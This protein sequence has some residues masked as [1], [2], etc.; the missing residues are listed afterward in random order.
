[1]TQEENKKRAQDDH[2]KYIKEH[3]CDK[4]GDKDF[5]FISY[6]SDDWETVLQDVVYRLVSE[7]GLNVYFDGSFDSHNSLWIHQFPENM[8]NERCK[9]VLAFLDDKYATS[10]AT[11]LELMYSQTYLANE[12][13]V[14]PVNLSKLTAITSE[15]DTGLGTELYSDGTKN[16]NA[17]SE[18]NLFDETFEELKTREIWKKSGFMYKKKKLSQKICSI[19]VAELVA[20]LG[21]NEN[22]YE[23]GQALDGIVES[24]KNACGKSVFS[25]AESGPVSKPKPEP[26]SKSKPES[27]FVPEVAIVPRSMSVPSNGLTK[28]TTLKEFSEL[29][30]Y[31]EFCE[32][33]QKVRCNEKKQPFDYLMAAL[34]RGC[35]EKSFKTTKGVEVVLNH[36]R[37]NYCTYAVSANLN[38]DNPVCGASQYTWTSNAR[39]AAGM[40]GSGALGENSSVFNALGEE[41]TLGQIEKH[42]TEKTEPAFD[43]NDNESVL[44]SLNAILQ[45]DV[46]KVL[47]SIGV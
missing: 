31:P 43:I 12:L 15:E 46:K 14:V 36:A 3:I 5:V 26:A 41:V 11:L 19:M 4:D 45:I 34:L 17:K 42:F 24:I 16:V 13:P 37:W 6:K 8:E 38:R 44:K 22:P 28:D 30:E 21:V 29:C 1:M 20:Y 32:E 39:K 7:Y 18:K 2:V 25:T 35:D 9:G 27:A 40:K 33:L 23:K 47:S 10:Y